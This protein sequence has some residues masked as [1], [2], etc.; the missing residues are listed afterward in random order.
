VDRP[1]WDCAAGAVGAWA[2]AA[3]WGAFCAKA[4]LA[5]TSAVTKQLTDNSLIWKPSTLT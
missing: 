4:P 2:G 1:G 5:A 3:D